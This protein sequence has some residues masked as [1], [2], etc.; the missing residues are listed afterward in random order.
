VLIVRFKDLDR[1]ALLRESAAHVGPAIGRF[2]V[3]TPDE[4][5]RE[6][7]SA[8]D[9]RCT[10][11]PE[12]DL[13]PEIAENRD[14]PAGVR[15]QVAKLALVSRTSGDFCL[16][17]SSD[18]LCVRPFSA[19]DVI[20]QGKALYYRYINTVHHER[21]T[22]A[23]EVLGLKRSG[24][25]HGSIPYLLCKPVVTG[26]IEHLDQRA[27]ETLGPSSSWRHYLLQRRGWVLGCVYFTFLEA[28][29]LEDRYYFPGEDSLYGNCVWAAEDWEDWDPEPSFSPSNESYFSVV[30][31]GPS[32]T[33]D[34]VRG[35]IAPYFE[36]ETKSAMARTEHEV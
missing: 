3:V 4:E 2:L 12:S 5:Y 1:F 26:L 27:T 35:R 25:V 23:E 15:L 21:Y 17:L 8:A 13:I 36:R 28:F 20:R 33:A 31:V 34:A 7:S 19:S 18:V 11:V 24:W 16:D 29:G 9:R 6:V 32:I 14:V 10:V 30:Q 22:I